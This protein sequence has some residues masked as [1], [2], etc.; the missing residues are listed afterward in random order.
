[1]KEPL[2][3]AHSDPETMADTLKKHIKQQLN[4]HKKVAADQLIDARIAKY[5]SMGKFLEI[6][7]SETH[8]S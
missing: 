6:E 5:R 8:E 3:R 1:I 7:V 4:N 2:G